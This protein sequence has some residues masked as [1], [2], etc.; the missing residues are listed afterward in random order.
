M[1][2]SSKVLF[3][4]IIHSALHFCI[5]I[6]FTVS[7]QEFQYENT[8][9]VLLGIQQV[10]LVQLTLSTMSFII[11]SCNWDMYIFQQFEHHE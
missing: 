8:F 1:R 3:Y 6:Q 4:L 2:V 11:I 5:K 10:T 7:K 9:R